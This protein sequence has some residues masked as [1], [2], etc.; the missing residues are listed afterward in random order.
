MGTPEPLGEPLLDP[1]ETGTLID[2]G[3]LAYYLSQTISPKLAGL[4]T[5]VAD[6]KGRDGLL[7]PTEVREIMEGAQADLDQSAL[8]DALDL[9]SSFEVT[10]A[11][12]PPQGTCA[13][14][15][16]FRQRAKSVLKF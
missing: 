7:T 13:A 15:D 5:A 8:E 3:E 12:L 16:S 10:P 9:I 1:V 14:D 2:A 11:E 4:I 6:Q